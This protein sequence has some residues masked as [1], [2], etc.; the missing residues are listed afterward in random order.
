MSSGRALRLPPGP[1]RGR[2]PWGHQNAS[3]ARGRSLARLRNLC[4]LPLNRKFSEVSSARRCAQSPLAGGRKLSLNLDLAKFSP[5][6][7]GC[8]G[9]PPC[10]AARKPEATPSAARCAAAPPPP[11]AAGA[12]QQQIRIPAHARPRGPERPALGYL[13]LRPGV[14]MSSGRALR[15]P[16]GPLRGRPQRG[17]ADKREAR[18]ARSYMRTAGEA[19]TTPRPSLPALCAPGARGNARLFAFCIPFARKTHEC[20][21]RVL[22]CERKYV[23]N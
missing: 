5:S 11:C 7:P 17:R 21:C 23:E 10:G 14:G 9:G 18:P 12:Y 16:P 2:P 6:P 8:Q 1:L 22:K 3:I 15:L 13:P 4:A 19:S 20:S